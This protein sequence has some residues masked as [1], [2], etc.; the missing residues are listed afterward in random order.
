MAMWEA[1]R[2]AY[3]DGYETVDFGIT[4]KHIDSLRL[5]KEKWGGV[6][7]PLHYSYMPITGASTGN[8]RQSKAVKLVGEIIRKT[9]LPVFKRI[10]PVILQIMV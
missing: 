8:F 1:I 5:Y 10:S 2:E 9:P 3:L 6:S 7:Y 4:P